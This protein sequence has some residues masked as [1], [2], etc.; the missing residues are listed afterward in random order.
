MEALLDIYS[1]SFPSWAE[2]NVLKVRLLRPRPRNGLV[3]SAELEDTSV[4]VIMIF[5]FSS[6]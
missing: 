2:F 6:L 1:T 3:D 5:V 4:S